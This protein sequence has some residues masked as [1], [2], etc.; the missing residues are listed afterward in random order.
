[1][2]MHR[3]EFYLIPFLLLDFV[4]HVLLEQLQVHDFVQ[5]DS[6]VVDGASRAKQINQ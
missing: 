2:I 4:S 5:R 3:I 1:M 6:F